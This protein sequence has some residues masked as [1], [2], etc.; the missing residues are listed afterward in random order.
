VGEIA[1]GQREIPA[2][3][4]DTHCLRTWGRSLNADSMHSTA[5]PMI[6]RAIYGTRLKTRS[7]ILKTQRLQRFMRSSSC[8]PIL[9]SLPQRLNHWCGST[10]NMTTP[11]NQDPVVNDT[12]PHQHITDHFEAHKPGFRSWATTPQRRRGAQRFRGEDGPRSPL[13]Q[14]FTTFSPDCYA[15]SESGIKVPPALR[16]R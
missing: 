10:N 14:D 11:E 16:V 15:T 5:Q 8:W 1:R 3:L 9:N 13:C 6:R 12:A 7:N 4:W 2:A